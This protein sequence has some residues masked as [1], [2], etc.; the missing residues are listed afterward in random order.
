[1]TSYQTVLNLD[2]DGIG[3]DFI[4]GKENLTLLD[5]TVLIKIKFYLQE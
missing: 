3:L 2:F 1:M 5:R 4:E